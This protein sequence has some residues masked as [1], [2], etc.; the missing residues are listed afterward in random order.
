[1]TRLAFQATQVLLAT[2]ALSVLACGGGDSGNPVAPVPNSLVLSSV[3]IAVN[4]QPMADGASLHRRTTPGGSTRFEAHLMDGAHGAVGDQ[5]HMRFDRPM[6]MMNP[7][8]TM[9]LFDDG[10]HGDRFA[11]DGVYCY[12]DADGSYGLHMMD[13]SMGRYRYEFWGTDAGGHDSNHMSLSVTV[14]S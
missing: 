8:G 5:V 4:G 12:E 11:N 9:P 13:A 14:T 2:A 7:N 10:T 3:T 1:M 6:G